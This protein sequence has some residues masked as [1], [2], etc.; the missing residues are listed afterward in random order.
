[1]VTVPLG[2]V[3]CELATDAGG[4]K[5]APDTESTE[6][7]VEAG[8]RLNW[9]RSEVMDRVVPEVELTELF[10]DG[11]F[12]VSRDTIF[13]PTVVPVLAGIKSVVTPFFLIAVRG[14][15]NEEQQGELVSP[16]EYECRASARF[17]CISFS[18]SL[19]SCRSTS[20]TS[21]SVNTVRGIVTT[22]D[23]GS[24]YW[25]DCSIRLSR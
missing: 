2:V 9:L 8:V 24:R 21:A 6:S 18:S 10:F 23:N 12:G 19:L 16:V 4:A 3:L 22:V 20:R 5:D 11:A 13:I 14:G 7:I 17:C 1:M 25:W 15:W